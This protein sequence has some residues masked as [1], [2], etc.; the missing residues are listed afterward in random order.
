MRRPPLHPACKIF[1]ALGEAE[2][3]ELA[4]DISVNGLLNPIVLLDGKLLD[5]RNRFAA[6]KFAGIDP[7]FVEFDGDDPIAWVMSQNLI[8]RHLTA[9]QRA[10]VALDLLP[11][12]EQEAKQRQRRSNEFRA[13]G[14]SAQTGANRSTGKSAEIAAWLARS[15]TRYVE[16]VKSIRTESP[17]LVDRIRTGE[18]TIPDARRLITIQHQRRTE[19]KARREQK[20]ERTWKIT[21][22]QTPIECD[23][24]IADP[25]YG[26]T[27]ESWEP[28]NLE[29]FTR[30]WCRKW[31]DSG[32]D[33]IAIFWS[34]EYLFEG[35]VWL[36]ES[37]DGYEFQ[38]LLS[39]HAKNSS[40]L[41]SR[42][43][44]KMSWEPIFLYR[45]KGATR[46]VI[47]SR[48]MWSTFQHNYDCF[49]AT[50]PQS[51]Y[52]GE[53]HK[54][55]PCQKPVS[56]MRWL[57]YALSE[58]GEMVASPFCGVAPCGIAATQLG[59]QFHGIEINKTYRRLAEERI[60]AYGSRAGSTP[61][62]E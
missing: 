50:I 54:Q 22:N 47:C 20:R 3:N 34:Q 10:V 43:L 32:A 36:D 18:L 41:K 49:V 15:S 27:K 59:R 30:G 51:D 13:N 39:W 60:A 61:V 7:R 45:R 56:V 55:H 52:H 4:D 11:L 26:I 2:L 35:R 24:L 48:K 6:C 17:D 38:Q 19:E 57:I 33:F 12:L 25:P 8:R 29:A 14:Q 5:G 53:D 58:P 23:L 16:A 40:A 62:E 44:F 1:P 46:K 21:A 31:S 37:L 9:S 28:E 42:P